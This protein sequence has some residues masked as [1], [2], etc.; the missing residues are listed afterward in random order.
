MARPT[1]QKK[2]QTQAPSPLL[3]LHCLLPRE[4]TT[5]IIIITIIIIIINHHYAYYY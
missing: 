5:T 3:H 1:G 2:S 4:V